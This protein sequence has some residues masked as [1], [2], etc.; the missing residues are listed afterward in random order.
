MYTFLHLVKVPEINSMTEKHFIRSGIRTIKIEREALEIIETRIDNSFVKAC[1]L[2][3]SCQG[4]VIVN[5]VGKSGHIGRKIAATLASTGTPAFFVHPGEASHGDFGMITNKDVV[6]A[7]SNSGNTGELVNLLP[8]IKRLGCPLVSLTGKP[9][10]PIAK[11]ADVNLDV[12]VPREACPHNLAPTS[13][14]AAAMAMGDA[15]AIALLEDRGFSEEDFA[16][17]H[18]AGNL[19]K[20]LSLHVSDVMRTGKDIPCISESAD[21][22]EALAE[23]SNKS[24]GMTVVADDLNRAVGIFTDGD[25][26]RCITQQIDTT[27]TQVN[28]VMTK[29][30]KTVDTDDLAARALNIMESHKIT[31][32]VV[33]NE[34]QH[35]DGVIHLHDILRAGLI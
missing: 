5:G 12:S 20:Q 7:I 32:L 27:S 22:Q 26:R 28:A 13:S 2:I 16:F 9:G 14:T 4:R 21:L 1:E 3:R 11:S 15:L 33:T 17:S 34:K 6:I 25:L 10:S 35:I 23:I 31:S 18:P 30:P 24:L 19:G 8:M 29:N